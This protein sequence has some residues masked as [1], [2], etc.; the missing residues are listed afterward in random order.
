MLEG[1][2][3]LTPSEFAKFYFDFDA[4]PY[5]IEALNSPHK[6]IQLVW[7]RQTGK[8]TIT[9]LRGLNYATMNDDSTV[10]ILAPKEQQAIRLFRKMKVFITKS[11]QKHPELRLTDMIDRETR[12]VIEWSNGSEILCYSIADDGNNIRG[13]TSHLTIIDEVADVQNPD[14]WS[15]INPM[16]MVTGG[17]QWLIG[18]LKGVNNQFYKIF[19]EPIF[20]G[21]HSYV[22]PSTKNPYADRALL[23]RDKLRMSTG[24]WNQEYLCIPMEEADSFFPYAL[25]KKIIG[26]FEEHLAPVPHPGFS[27]YLGV[28]PA[29][30]GLDSTV[31][32][33][34]MSTPAGRLNLVRFIETKHQTLPQID[35]NIRSLHQQWGFRKIMVDCTGG[36]NVH[37]FLMKDGIPA[38]GIYFNIKLKEEIF[39]FLKS[40][41]QG[42]TFTMYKNEEAIKQ[43]MDMRYEYTK[44]GSEGHIKIYSGQSKD[45]KLPGGDDYVTALALVM[46]ATRMPSQP[47]LFSRVNSIFRRNEA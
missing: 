26:D 32:A 17:G 45:S 40:Q 28:D 24:M 36:R 12:R 39:Q 20:Y 1:I 10:V 19:K 23:E 16:S 2:K 47:V 11:V 33:I 37:E 7:G 30:E 35:A 22:V 5:Q 34:L 31:Y 42:E 15:A 43:L 4:L 8:S 18:T 41:M 13:L 21:F 29:G 38:E 3:Q 44:V 14:A 9:A 25:V 6:N 46:W 27:Y